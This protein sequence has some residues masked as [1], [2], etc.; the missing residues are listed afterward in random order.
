M[1]TKVL[2]GFALL[3]GGV[4]LSPLASL[5]EAS[6]I[7][8]PYPIGRCGAYQ[9]ESVIHCYEAP[10]A[11]GVFTA[12][13]DPHVVGVGGPDVVS[14]DTGGRAL[15]YVRLTPAERFVADP[16]GASL[17]TKSVW[18]ERNEKP[19][20]QMKTFKCATFTWFAECEPAQWMGPYGISPQGSNA[21][22]ASDKALV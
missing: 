9:R 10:H 19:G 18:E 2:L 22:Y 6:H 8:D 5:A 12:A 13:T 17:P 15:Y 4:A 14:I 7:C 20:L 21:F 16:M 11:A 3:V 1:R